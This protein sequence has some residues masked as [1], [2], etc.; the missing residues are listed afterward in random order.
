MKDAAV[1][2]PFAIVAQVK[3]EEGLRGL[4]KGTTPSMVSKEAGGGGSQALAGAAAV[5]AAACACLM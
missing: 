5:A 3:R 4:W 2:N 1:R